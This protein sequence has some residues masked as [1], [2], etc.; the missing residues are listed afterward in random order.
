M[1]NVCLCVPSFHPWNIWQ[2]SVKICMTGL[3]AECQNFQCILI[4]NNDVEVRTCEE[5]TRDKTQGYYFIWQLV[6]AQRS[7]AWRQAK[8]RSRCSNLPWVGVHEFISVSLYNIEVLIAVFTGAG[9]VTFWSQTHVASNKNYANSWFQ[10]FVVFWMSYAFFWV[11]HWRLNSIC[12]RFGTHC[13]IFSGMKP[14]WC[15]FHS[16]L[17]RIKGLCMFR[18]LLAHPQEALHKRNLVYCV[19]VL[20]VGCAR[21]GAAKWQNTHA[22]YQVP[23]VERLLRMSK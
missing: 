1:G 3:P 16:I 4:R 21:I 7:S 9:N 23:F 15:T 12:Q 19:R 10:T 20:S 8:Q 18:A 22:I 14:T 6:I 2:N 13:P 11:I 17:L 5:A